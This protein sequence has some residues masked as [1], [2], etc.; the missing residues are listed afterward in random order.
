MT[1]ITLPTGTWLF[2]KVPKGTQYWHISESVLTYCGICNNAM[3]TLP[4]GQWQVFSLASAM[5]EELSAQMCECIVWIYRD[6][7]YSKGY[8]FNIKLAIES[9]PT[10]MS[11]HGMYLKNPLGERPVFFTNSNS[12]LSSSNWRELDA[13]WQSCEDKV[14]EYV[15]LRQVK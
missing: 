2:V 4:P 8:I 1:T 6:Y 5:T 12:D 7:S 14:S 3:Q 15:I 11:A 9:F 13:K 10:L